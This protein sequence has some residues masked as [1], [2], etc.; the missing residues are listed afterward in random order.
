MIYLIFADLFWSAAAWAVDWTKLD[1]IPIWAWPFVV[2]CPIYPLLIA[3]VWISLFKGGKVNNFLLSFAAL[4]TV[5]FGVLSIFYYPLK[6]YF[7]GFAWV[8]LG[9]IFWVLFYAFQGLYLLRRYKIKLSASLPTLIFLVIALTINLKFKTFGYLSFDAF[10][11][12]SLCFLFVIGVL[13]SFGVF[14]MSRNY[15]AKL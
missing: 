11:D 6:M 3:L 2:I 8:D 5:V 13:G 14:L 9:Q 1:I 10:S 7:Q 12:P 15:W 4:P